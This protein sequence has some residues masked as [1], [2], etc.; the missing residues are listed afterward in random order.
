VT[1]S[2]HCS[3]APYWADRLGKR[4]L[5]ARQLSARGGELW[6]DVGSSRVILRGNAVLVLRGEL[7]I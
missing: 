4:L 3:L 7:L 6:C 1:G 5:H 2:T